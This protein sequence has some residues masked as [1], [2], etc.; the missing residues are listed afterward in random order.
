LIT[1]LLDKSCTYS[2]T[3][4]TGS[5]Y[6]QKIRIFSLG[7]E[8]RFF[9]EDQRMKI[10]RDYALFSDSKAARTRAITELAEAYGMKA[11]PFIHEIINAIHDD[12]LRGYCERCIER[13]C[14]K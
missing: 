13:L 9:T 14:V 8:E 6:S 1:L 12:W 10:L 2:V 11:V 7:L 3:E 4:A 5:F